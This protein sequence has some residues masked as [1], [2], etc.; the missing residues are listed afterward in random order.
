MYQLGAYAKTMLDSTQQQLE[1]THLRKISDFAPD[2]A[3]WIVFLATAQR[4]MTVS[5]ANN[6][7]AAPHHAHNAVASLGLH[8]GH[9]DSDIQSRVV[10]VDTA[11]V[12]T[13]HYTAP[14]GTTHYS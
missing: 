6:I 11:P 9:S 12:G 3:S 2:V 7:N 14:V 8:V 13:T 1:V 5:A 10:P 4:T